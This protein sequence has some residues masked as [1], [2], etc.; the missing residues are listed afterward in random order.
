[1]NAIPLLFFVLDFLSS[2]GFGNEG[3]SQ[4]RI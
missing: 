3:F 4:L 2:K 1:M